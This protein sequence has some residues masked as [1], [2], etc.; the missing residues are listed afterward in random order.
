MGSTL[1]TSSVFSLGY[2]YTTNKNGEDYVAYC[3]AEIPGFSKFG[4]YKGTGNSNGSFINVGFK[5]AWVLVKGEDFAGNWNLFDIKRPGANPINDRLFPNLSDAETDGSSSNNQI[6]I[7]SNGFKLRG[8]NVDTNS[9]GN[10]YIYMAFAD[11]T[12][13]N[14]FNLA[15]N[16]F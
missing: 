13:L 9:A 6:D 14:Q 8:S 4:R 11:Q 3:W 12:S 7:Y 10:T 2:N 16:A 5:P 15:V 1:P